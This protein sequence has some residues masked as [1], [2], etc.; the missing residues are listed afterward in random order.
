MPSTGRRALTV[1][2]ALSLSVVGLSTVGPTTVH[3]AGTAIFTES[4]TNNSVPDPHW[5]IG[6]SG[7]TPCLTATGNTTVGPIKSCTGT[8]DAAG[9]GA[10]R[11]TSAGTGQSGFIFYNSPLP[12]TAGINVT[13]DTYQYSGTG[14]DGIAFFMTDGQY[15][16]LTPGQSGG[17]LG[18]AGGNHGIGVGNGVAHGLFGL[19]LDAYGNFSNFENNPANGG[20]NCPNSYTPS[21]V[22]DAVVLRG[23]GNADEV[24]YCHLAGAAAAKTLHVDAAPDRTDGSRNDV[25]RHVHIVVDP[26]SDAAPK[27]T[28]S[29]DGT[30]VLQAA[31]PAM[32]PTVKF[33]WTASTGGSTNIHEIQNVTVTTINA[34]GPTLSV[35]NTV[36]SGGNFASGGPA[37]DAT[38]TIT[39]S[40]DANF[41]TKPFT[42]TVPMPA[43]LGF[44]GANSVD[45]TMNC[46]ASTTTL[47]SCTDTPTGYGFAPGQSVVVDLLF[48]PTTTY[49]HK[50]LVL[51]ASVS[52]TDGGSPTTNQTLQIYPRAVPSAITT[53]VNVPAT[54]AQ[55]ANGTAPFSWILGAAG[56]AALV[57]S[58]TVDASGNVTMTPVAGASGT[59]TIPL[60]VQDASTLTSA[61]AN[62]PVTVRP[63]VSAVVGSGTGP[64]PV[65]ANVPPPVGTGPFVYTFATTPNAGTQGTA[66]FVAGSPEQVKFTPVQGFSG[67]VPTFTYR[68]TD[69]GGAQSATSTVDIMVNRPAAPTVA[70]V[71]G[72]IDANTI[73]TQTVAAP[74]GASPFGYAIIAPPSAGTET[75]SNAGVV[76]FTPPNN[77]SGIYNSTYQAQDQ[78][79][80]PSNS[81]QIQVTV[82]PVAA[83]FAGSTLATSPMTLSAPAPAGTGPFTWT[84]APP[85]THGPLSMNIA[86]GQVTFTATLGYAG[87]FTF[88]YSVSDNVGTSSTAKL[89][90][91]TVTAPPA[92]VAVPYS[93]TQ[94]ADTHVIAQL[95]AP[96][97]GTA[98]FIYSQVAAPASGVL[99]LAANGHI[100]FTPVTGTSGIVTFTYQVTD[101]YGSAS[102][103]VTVTLNFLP[104]AQ[105]LSGSTV[106]PQPVTI[107][108]ASVDGTGPFTYTL[109]QPPTAQGTATVNQ[110]NGA[111]TFTPKLGFTGLA[112]FSYTVTG[113]GPT[114]SLSAQVTVTVTSPPRPTVSPT[115]ATTLANTAVD[116]TPPAAVGTAPLTYAISTAPTR[117]TATISAAG[118]IH[119]T[120]NANVSGIDT[121]HYTA[122]DPYSQTSVPATVTIDVFPIAASPVTGSSVGP[123]PVIATPGAP[124]GTGAFT[125]A[126][127]PGSV[128]PLTKGTTVENP[129]TGQITFT[130]VSGFNGT[131]TFQYTVSD[132]AGLTSAPGTVTLTV[133][134]P[135]GP[136]VSPASA[137]T[138][139]NAPVDIT[140]PPATGT[141]PLSYAISTTPTRGTAT[142]SS[143]GVIHY[144]P[145]VNVSGV[146]TLQYT[147]SD[148]YA[149]TSVPATVTITVHPVAASPVTGSST[150]PNPV[151]A[152]PGPPTGTGPFTYALVPGS[153]PPTAE[154]TTVEGSASGQITFTPVI[155]FSGTVTF[156]YTVTDAASLTSAPGTVTFTVGKPASPAVSPTSATTLA[157]TAVD[158]TPPP[159]TGTAPLAYMISTVPTRG[160]ATISS[161][162]VIHYTPNANASGVDTLQY[163]ASDSYGQT[164]VPASVTITVH[165]I[166][167]SPV[168]GSST[169]PNPVVAM[170]GAPTGSGPFTYSLVAGSLPSLSQGATAEDPTTGQITFTPVSGF[171]GMVSFQYTVSDDAAV[172]SAPGAVTFTVNK[173]ATPVVSP[174]SATT[175]ANTAVDVTPPAAT[176]TAPL[177]YAISTAPTR[178][179]ATISAA[180]VIHF[181][182]AAD[183]S[184]VVTLRYT[185]TDPY[186]ATSAPALVTITVIPIAANPVTGSSTGPNPVI[187]TPG[188]PI[189]SGPFTYALVPASLPLTTKGTTAEDPTT[190]QITFTPAIGFSGTV[191][192]QYT[193]TDTDAVTSGPG[194]VTFT[195]TKPSA[196]VANAGTGVTVSG[197]STTVTASTASGVG[198]FT[199]AISLPPGHGSASIASGNQLDYTSTAPYSGLDALTY[200]ATDPYGTA[201][202]AAVVTISVYP[203]AASP[204]LGSSTGPN[205]VVAT[206]GAPTGSGP[207]TYSLV[208]G[209]RPSLSQGATAEDPTT[210]QITFAPVNGFSGG[211]TFQYTVTDAAGLTSAPGTVFFDVSTPPGPLVFPTS[212]TTLASTAV[213]V[214]LPAF[215]GTPPLTYGILTQPTLGTATI[216]TSGLMHYTP[217]TGVSGIDTLTY[218]AMD[219]WGQTGGPALV[220][221]SISPVAASPVTGSSTGPNPV[222]ATPGAP[223]GT[224]PFTYS[225]VSGSLPAS[226]QGTT[227]E[228]PTSGQITFTPVAG[229]S[230][231][232]AFQYTVTDAATLTSA[233]GEVNFTVVKPAIPAVSPTSATTTA[234]TPLDITPPAATGTAPLTYVIST[235]PTRGAASISA[236][237]VIHYTP[238]PNVSGVDTLQYTATDAYS[239]TS[240]PATVTITVHPIA[241]SPVTGSSTGPNPVIATPGAPTG[242]GPFT[243]NLVPGSLPPLADGTTVEDPTTGQITFTPAIG[244][245]GT[246]TF[247]Y[248]VTDTNR[249]TSAPATVTFTVGTPAGPAVSSTTA[250]TPANVPV[251]ITPPA[252]TGTAPLTFAI[253]TT[254]TRGT[255]TIS[256]A[257]VMHYT[258]TTNVSGVDTLQ[259]TATDAYAQPSLPATVTVVVTPTVLDLTATMVANTVLLRPTP[260][261]AGSGPFTYTVTAPSHGTATISSSGTV[262]YTPA[263]NFGGTDG[264][265]YQATDAQGQRSNVGA[266]TITV[267][268]PASPTV[269]DVSATTTVYIA[270]GLGPATHSGSGP[271]TWAIGTAP[272]SGIVTIDPATGAMV[273]TPAPGASGTVAYTFVATDRYGSSSRPATATVHVMPVAWPIST[274]VPANSGPVV[275]GLPLPSGTGPFRCALV[276]SSLPPASAGSVTVNAT[277]CIMTFTP[278]AGFAGT[279]DVPYAIT[280]SAGLM[281]APAIA[282]FNVLAATTTSN[283][284]KTVNT[285]LVPDTGA[286]LW[287]QVLQGGLVMILGMLLLILGAVTRRRRERRGLSA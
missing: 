87:T 211:V 117:G 21:L 262:T 240:V 128:P 245:S 132:G 33:G 17:Y 173:P 115:S 136:G 4:F 170:P 198:P 1:L 124:V 118:V 207:F 165:P 5:V 221:I 2:L 210:G 199:Y 19:G 53:T 103:P 178:G 137:T 86:S 95:P 179:A 32:S 271:F 274:T 71:S 70:A 6:G 30:Q 247:A 88:P 150:G 223:I 183:T 224:G 172:P 219:A 77:T 228:D 284:N 233:P 38:Y 286:H 154:G 238:N 8:M 48:S 59:T 174:A 23:P 212:A 241:A 121:L 108:G 111:I 131:V 50:N 134:K 148:A 100:D 14:A 66:Q 139:A 250:T 267:T 98:P 218:W 29:I 285:P 260:G 39:N 64:A 246:V 55:G 96:S 97:S 20:G 73:F 200:T 119:Y 254:P 266:V 282:A 74:T 252:A 191:T 107:A 133:N 270:A 125:Y 243:Y 91:I 135:T 192:F 104:V 52:S 110:T 69:A 156:Q 160:T 112:S 229:F 194:T 42:L 28:V 257:G 189:G 49:S 93:S 193:V 61:V 205:P 7:F 83:A 16:L 153:L 220:T 67:A 226:T 46:A 120:P 114:T 283:T 225:L 185:A 213:D 60:S 196:P 222:I 277:T 151:I 181:T 109:T 24:N 99:V 158:I 75:I 278:A 180:G 44:T 113:A 31:E 85:Q 43:G 37:G 276:T 79:G 164:S 203:I 15:Q 239:Q 171:S 175:S 197:G 256:S 123:N 188:A 162:G 92:P 127:V 54:V 129:A 141:A 166:A 275:I 201:S 84:A 265:S 106:G 63:T 146:D 273:F 94:N 204:V 36:S 130:P 68:V 227:V 264:F 287:R 161:A 142:I 208:P 249:G 41:E 76:N 281:S 184:G 248:T 215:T 209:S 195:V 22:R 143:A 82:R 231:A 206:P 163:T 235:T 255:A 152:T 9:A 56:S 157:N 177:T 242:S 253:S 58:A 145:N 182:P 237:G 269:A 90:T 234:N 258:P 126:L 11:L 147:A 12:D 138:T 47:L 57:S 26:S 78:Y 230:G 236:A 45:P 101:A 268:K 10:A 102:L 190:G 81:G 202:A 116:I 263:H 176:G 72:I 35:S 272:P 34:L 122:T 279:V 149:Q 40:S 89:V 13:F 27:V 214:P 62:I 217:T 280:D 159:A 144:T 186:G 168:T 167:A 25:V 251:N 259:Y 3:A 261:T 105:D 155:G 51:T 65:Y 80:Q 216:S 244:F 18:Y 187:A 140:P 232:V 169:G